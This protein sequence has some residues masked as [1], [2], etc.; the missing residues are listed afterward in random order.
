MKPELSR[1]FFLNNNKSNFMNI[2]P[3]GPELFHADG[4]ID[5]QT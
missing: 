2:R 4:Q 3:V 5:R 1:Q